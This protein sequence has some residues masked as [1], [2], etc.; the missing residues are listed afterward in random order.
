MLMKVAHQIARA[1]GF[2]S[3][4]LTV[5]PANRVATR[6]T[7]GCDATPSVRIVADLLL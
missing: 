1:R 4:G 6:C 5:D 7:S 2:D 3:I